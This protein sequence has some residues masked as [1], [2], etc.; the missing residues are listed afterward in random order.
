[1]QLSGAG[2]IGFGKAQV[3]I[4]RRNH[5]RSENGVRPLFVSFPVSLPCMGRRGVPV[6]VHEVVV[7]L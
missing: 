5:Q 2:L 1:M 7:A 3:A 4:F 6:E